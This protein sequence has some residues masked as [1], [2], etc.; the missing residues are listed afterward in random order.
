MFSGIPISG[1]AENPFA[2]E[3]FGRSCKG[4]SPTI[5]EKESSSIEM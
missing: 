5:L 2:Q 4:T 1:R 3:W